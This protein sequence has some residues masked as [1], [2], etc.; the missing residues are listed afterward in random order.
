MSGAH[1]RRQSPRVHVLPPPADTSAQQRGEKERNGTRGSLKL[2]K[3]LQLRA[4][5]PL[6]Q[7][8]CSQTR[9][10]IPGSCPDSLGCPRLPLARAAGPARQSHACRPRARRPRMLSDAATRPGAAQPGQLL[11]G[12]FPLPSPRCCRTAAIIASSDAAA[13]N[14]K[15]HQKNSESHLGIHTARCESIRCSLSMR[16]TQRRGWGQG[17]GAA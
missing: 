10:T 5:I 13:K 6:L 12:L 15:S 14:S 4:E 9:R 7:H 17:D 1:L 3:P 8:I 2:R 16:V 11:Q